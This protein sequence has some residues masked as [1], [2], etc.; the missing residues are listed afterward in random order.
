MKSYDSA[1][2]HRWYRDPRTR[3]TSDRALD[4]KVHLALSAAEYMLGR[5]VRTVLDVGCGEGRW[6]VAL[7]RIRPGISYTGVES[8]EYAVDTFGA[9]RNIRRGSF[10]TLRSLKLRG[11]FDLVVC[12]DVL[13]Y[14]S[15]EDLAPGLREI[16]RLLGGVAYIEAY[17]REDDMVGDMDGW[18]FRS[19]A[20]YRREFKAARLTHCGLY[21]FIDA[22][23][24]SAVN[25]LEIC[26]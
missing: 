14:V 12:A 9:S 11:P 25:A 4:R 16:R 19:A 7:R 15:K 24:I 8:S 3:V 6:F 18:H 13:Q 17:A 26:S 10:G 21:C 5:R 2:F 1:Y 23:K 22:D 20:T